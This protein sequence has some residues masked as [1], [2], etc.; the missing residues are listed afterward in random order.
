MAPRYVHIG[1]CDKLH[2]ERLKRLYVELDET[3]SILRAC[4]HVGCVVR[5]GIKRAIDLAS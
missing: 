3:T 5:T 4:M 2:D 1:P